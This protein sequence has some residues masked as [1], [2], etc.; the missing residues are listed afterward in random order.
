MTPLETVPI[1][2]ISTFKNSGEIERLVIFNELSSLSEFVKTESRF[3]VLGKGS[4]TLI[5]PR[6]DNKCFIKLS[7]TLTEESV[8]GTLMSL[9]AGMSG[10]K[11]LKLAQLHGLSGLEFIAG[12][13]TTVG[14]MVAMNFGCWGHEFADVIERVHVMDRDGKTEWGQKDE[15]AFAYRSSAVEEKEW[16]VLDVALKLVKEAPLKIHKR[17]QENIHLRL[18]KQPLRE[19]TF[20]SV[21]KNPPNDFAGRIIESLGYKGSPFRK[22]IKMSDAH[23]NFMVNEGSGTYDDALAL[24]QEIQSRTK[25][26]LGIDLALE[27]KLA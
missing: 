3:F 21:F 19:N 12:V 6:S 8:N 15:F 24:I 23:A 1:S 17:A 13:P 26:E 10:N 14:G 25:S 9:P 22:F 11:A 7:P 18:S 2:E 27:V 4:N 16:V 20:G 5:N